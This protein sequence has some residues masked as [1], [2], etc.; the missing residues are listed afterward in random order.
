MIHMQISEVLT[1]GWLHEVVLSR[2]HYKYIA[3]ATSNSSQTFTSKILCYGQ[4]C[5]KWLASQLKS[6]MCHTSLE[7][8]NHI[9]AIVLPATPFATCTSAELASFPGSFRGP[10]YEATAE[11]AVLLGVAL[12]LFQLEEK[13]L[14]CCTTRRVDMSMNGLQDI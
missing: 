8:T 1:L 3:Y 6:W 10:G 7:H 14:F 2:E 4:I 13:Q 5:N 12:Q 11:S 9:Q